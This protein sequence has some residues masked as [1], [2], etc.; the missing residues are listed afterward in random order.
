M[1]RKQSNRDPEEQWHKKEQQSAK[2]ED[3]NRPGMFE[4]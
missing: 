3:G 4:E 1:R 2:P